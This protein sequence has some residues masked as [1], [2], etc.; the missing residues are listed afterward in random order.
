MTLSTAALHFMA[1]S[2][3]DLLH[4]GRGRCQ[5]QPRRLVAQADLSY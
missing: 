2:R 5:K 3:I 1:T 4:C